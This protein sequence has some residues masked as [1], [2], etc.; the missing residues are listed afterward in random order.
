MRPPR[1]AALLVALLLT[2]LA[3]GAAVASGII[4]PAPG[5]PVPIRIGKTRPAL[6]PGE[7]YA[8]D[9][10]HHQGAIDWTAVA[11]DG[12]KASYIKAS[13]GQGMQDDHF[14]TNWD[15]ARAAGLR[16]G[17]YHFFS[18]CRTGEAQATNFLDAYAK[19]ERAGALPV[20]VDLEFGGNC[21][22]RPA[23]SDLDRE[24]ATF[25][26]R[27]ESQT[28][29]RALLY[30]F[31]DFERAYP[32]ASYGDRARWVRTIGARPGGT[33]SWW[34]ADDAAQV[35]GV[36]GGVDLNVVRG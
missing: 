32:L 9:V 3:L 13:E 31:D 6:Q 15:A 36:T 23:A 18:L 24:L 29:Q 17:A 21:D 34:Q 19:V 27:V 33:W 16:T 11:S 4:R 5:S 12:I 22:G 14:K 20:A 2:V 7:F 25:L 26:S 30:I 10:S 28:G 8:L 35:T 1:P